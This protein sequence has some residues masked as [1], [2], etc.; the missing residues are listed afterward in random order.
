[1][2]LFWLL[3]ALA[4]A[5]T[6]SVAAAQ[7]SS[8]GDARGINV[9]EAR[10]VIAPDM[11]S[12]KANLTLSAIAAI[13]NTEYPIFDPGAALCKATLGENFSVND[14]KVCQQFT[15]HKRK[16]LATPDHV[17]PVEDGV[18]FVL[19][20]WVD[21]KYLGVSVSLPAG[22]TICAERLIV[23]VHPGRHGRFSRVMPMPRFLGE[24][25][26]EF[27]ISRG[28]TSRPLDLFVDFEDQ[29]PTQQER[30][31]VG[32]KSWKD[33][34]DVTSMEILQA[35]LVSVTII[36]LL[37][38]LE[39]NYA[40]PIGRTFAQSFIEIPITAAI[41]FYLSSPLMREIISLSEQLLN[42]QKPQRWIRANFA[43]AANF[44]N[45]MDQPLSFALSI[46]AFLLLA[47]L[48]FV[49]RLSLRRGSLPEQVILW[50][51]RVIFFATLI[52][53]A[54]LLVP[55]GLWLLQN[56]LRWMGFEAPAL[57][58]SG[59]YALAA[60]S[61]LKMVYTLRLRSIFGIAL[62]VAVTILFPTDPV[63][64]GTA[65]IGI[66]RNTIYW[67][68]FL[69]HPIASLL[70]IAALT[71]FAYRI[72][73]DSTLDG[74]L[75]AKWLV[76]LLILE[77]AS[78]S[79]TSPT[80]AVAIAGVVLV[81][82][83]WIVTRQ[84]SLSQGQP[85][86]KTQTDTQ[87]INWGQHDSTFLFVVG[88]SAAFIYLMQYIFRAGGSDAPESFALL[89]LGSVARTFA[90][91]VTAGLVISRGGPYLRGDSAALK[92]LN[93]SVL[94]I[95]TSLASSLDSLRGREALIATLTEY[96][97]LIAALVLSAAMIYDLQ[98]AKTNDGHL[99]WRDLFKGTTLA[100]AI[101]IVSAVAVA[102]F[103]ALSP[104]LI[105]EIGASFGVLLKTALPHV[106]SGN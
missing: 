3:P 100:A 73:K 18:A 92:A 93:V 65:A 4:Y 97:G 64:K 96:M 35:L 28:T 22:S 98:R 15:E 38:Y 50:Q 25:R 74:T 13:P 54:A 26:A 82:S 99:Q 46:C 6:V 60:V 61:T 79:M 63:V 43:S 8:C 76:V 42:S 10:L 47:C 44:L 77:I 66:D 14:A 68:V 95:A 87:A 75:A 32:P 78:F 51:S 9:R 67:A 45:P 41:A 105:N 58:L 106:A 5:A 94:V 83:R 20:Q 55:I 24:D 33:S 91:G 56:R 11:V 17:E 1:M 81:S 69:G 27:E 48:Y 89:G 49:L 101:P 57:L 30:H 86:D 90:I 16:E 31:Y 53:T 52:S 70:Y 36:L 103:S 12:E 104:I 7:D 85:A 21:Q 37:T 2:R 62:L 59:L 102:V 23:E 72:A 84:T 80:N 34:I 39:R 88:G 71:G 19:S 29:A 40:L